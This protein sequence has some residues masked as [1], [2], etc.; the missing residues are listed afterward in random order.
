MQE[1]KFIKTPD[2]NLA[3]TLLTFGYDI[4]GMTA[5]E[6]K[7][8]QYIF[9][10]DDTEQIREKIKAFHAEQARCEPMALF[11]ARR[12]ILREIKNGTNS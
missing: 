8:G 9:F 5:S 6:F 11:R 2:I 12:Q 7:Q 1:K 4:K 10:F 3:S